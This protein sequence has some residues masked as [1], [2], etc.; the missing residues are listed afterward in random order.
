MSENFAPVPVQYH[1]TYQTRRTSHL[2]HLVLSVMTLGLW[3]P[4]WLGVSILNSRPQEQITRVYN[5]VNP[6]VAPVGRG[7][8]TNLRTE[9]TH[10]TGDTKVVIVV[11]VVAVAAIATPLIIAALGG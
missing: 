6:P 5:Q 7:R 10:T 4:I 2:L 3:L 9:R 11:A 1:V 8:L